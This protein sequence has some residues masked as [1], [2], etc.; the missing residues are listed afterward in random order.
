MTPRWKINPSRKVPYLFEQ[1]QNF[2]KTW[3]LEI[4]GLLNFLL[5]SPRKTPN[6][7]VHVLPST[8]TPTLSLGP[9]QDDHSSS[10][11]LKEKSKFL[12]LHPLFSVSY[13]RKAKKKWASFHFSLLLFQ[14]TLSGLRRA[15]CPL[16]SQVCFC[17][18]TINF[19][20]VQFILNELSSNHFL[21]FEIFVKILSL[22]SL[23]TH[24]PENRKNS[25]YLKI[26]RNFS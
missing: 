21:T 11:D 17:P 14:L 3:K 26:R 24:Y 9:T 4:H 23:A 10:V 5:V 7:G 18:E 16:R 22:E 12:S 25:D 1:R 8:S 6:F 2:S 19:F 13:V 20:S 15:T